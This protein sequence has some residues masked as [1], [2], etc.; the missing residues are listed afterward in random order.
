MYLSNLKGMR[1]IP[2]LETR[3]ELLGHYGE[4]LVFTFSDVDSFGVQAQCH[5]F[6]RH[7]TRQKTFQFSS[8]RIVFFWTNAKRSTDINCLLQQPFLCFSLSHFQSHFKSFECA[9]LTNR[10]FQSFSVSLFLSPFQCHYHKLYLLS[11]VNR[12]SS[13]FSKLALSSGIR[14]TLLFRQNLGCSGAKLFTSQVD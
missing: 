6:V 12:L 3:I 7:Q 9:E 4:R 2:A 8:T 11:E 10:F 14:S 13:V 1:L 5:N